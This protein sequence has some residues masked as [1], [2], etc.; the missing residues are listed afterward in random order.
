MGADAIGELKAWPKRLKAVT[1][2][3]FSYKVRDRDV[4]GDNYTISLSGSQIAKIAVPRAV[5]WGEILAFVLNENLPGAYPYTAAVYP[6][7]R[8]AEDPTRMFAG[9]GPP[10]RTNRRFPFR[11]PGST[12]VCTGISVAPSNSAHRTVDE[13]SD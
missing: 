8:E 5:D 1:Q 6:Y 7:R 9:E 10:E 3:K 2:E 12:L 4:T 11:T 13:V